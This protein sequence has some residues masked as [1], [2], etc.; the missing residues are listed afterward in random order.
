[1]Y[2]EIYGDLI[3]LAKQGKFDVIAHGCNCFCTMGAGIAV[4][5]K[6]AFGCDKFDLELTKEL[7]YDEDSGEEYEVAT[8]NKGNINKLG[9][10]DYEH[11][12]LWFKHPML[13]DG[14][15]SI[16]MNHKTVGQ[17]NVKD[18]I[19]VNA[20]TQYHWNRDTKPFDYEAFTL[21]MRKMNHTFKGMH[22]GLPQIGSHLA[23]GDW[24]LIKVIIQK[25]LKHCD[26]TI[27]IFDKK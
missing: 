11:K 21:C 13:K 19:V 14:E 9:C 6:L 4:P 20:Y 22:I 1:M 16:V 3:E 2:Q 27:V 10:I 26:V 15:A 24:E 23:G 25:E 17:E 12:Y 8:N 18:L 5:M 7:R